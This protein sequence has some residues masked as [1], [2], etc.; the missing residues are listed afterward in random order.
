MSVLLCPLCVDM[1]D[2]AKLL[3]FDEKAKKIAAYNILI[4]KL[5]LANW[6]LIRALSAFLIGIV[7][8]SEVNKMNVRNVGIVFSPTLNIPA[9]VFSAFLTDFD[10]IFGEEPNKETAKSVDLPIPEPLTPEDIR[11]PR[12]QL[13]SDIP[14]PSYNQDTFPTHNLGVTYEEVVWNSNKQPE[15]G[16]IPLQPSYETNI[17]GLR[18]ATQG[19]AASAAHL[20]P[21]PSIFQRT[22]GSTGIMRDSKARR[23]ESTTLDA[24]YGHR[25][26]S[27]PFL[28]HTP[29]SLFS[30][31][32]IIQH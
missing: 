27:L 4:S 19:R 22:L 3:E 5:P 14:T 32:C 7:K 16:F 18:L 29:R 13:F 21:G 26:L 8:N 17:P 30:T 11:S 31:A 2:M 24:Q 15:T 28:R 9:P 20:T 1:T 23:R 10:S 25:K 6:T 12:R